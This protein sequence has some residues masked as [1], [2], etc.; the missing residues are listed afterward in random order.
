MVGFVPSP[1]EDLVTALLAAHMG[2]H[3]GVVQLNVR[4]L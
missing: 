1:L 2:R 4:Q 3:P